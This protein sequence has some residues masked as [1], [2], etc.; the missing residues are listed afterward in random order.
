MKIIVK[1]IVGEKFEVT[2]E[3]KETIL[4]LKIKIED[5]AHIP[6]DNQ[7]LVFAG[8]TLEDENWLLDYNITEG[9]LINLSIKIR[10]H[11]PRLIFLEN[12]PYFKEI[13]ICLCQTLAQLKEKIGLSPNYREL[14][15]D[16]RKLQLND[17]NK[18]IDKLG[19]REL[20]ILSWGPD[21]CDYKEKFKN[22]LIQ[23]KDMGFSNERANLQILRVSAGNIRYAIE[24]Y[25]QY[26]FK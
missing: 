22:E 11:N 13:Y 5:K 18:D 8:R 19:I 9:S 26:F 3:P 4:N 15:A 16:G 23:L 14:Y 24:H 21:K 2:A 17:N 10:G 1:N 7:I 20:S 25:Y 12:K 6:P